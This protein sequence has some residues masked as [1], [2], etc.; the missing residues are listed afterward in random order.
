MIARTWHGA[1]PKK[2][3]DAYFEYVKET[4]ISDYRK[5]QGNLG[6]LVLRRNDKY[7]THFLLISLWDSFDSIKEFAGDDYTKARYYEDDKLF[8][9]DFEPVFHHEVLIKE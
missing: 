5:I 3:G 2:I 9:S 8:L 4:G 6:I 7:K 1:V